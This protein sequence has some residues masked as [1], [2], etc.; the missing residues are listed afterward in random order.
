M[1]FTETLQKASN[2]PRELETDT[3]REREK[4]K[5]KPPVAVCRLSEEAKEELLSTVFI[6][7]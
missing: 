6:C 4:G 7:R 3:E 5:P 2:Q 1:R